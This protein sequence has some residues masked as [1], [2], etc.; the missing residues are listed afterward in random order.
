MAENNDI[1]VERINLY[2]CYFLGAETVSDT[3]GTS[4]QNV[5]LFIRDDSGKT[6]KAVTF[7]KDGFPQIVIQLGDTP[8]KL[9]Q[10]FGCSSQDIIKA[11]QKLWNGKFFKVGQTVIIPQ[12]I[13]I[14]NKYLATRKTKEEAEEEYK[15][16]FGLH[17]SK[18]NVAKTSKTTPT[19]KTASTAKITKTSNDTEAT[20]TTVL[21]SN[22][23]EIEHTKDKEIKPKQELVKASSAN[24]TTKKSISNKWKSIYANYTP[25]SQVKYNRILKTIKNNPNLKNKDDARYI[26]NMVCIISERYG[27]DPEI[28][29]NILSHESNFV[30]ENW[31]MDPPEKKYKGVMQVGPGIIRSMY[32][33]P[34]DAT[35]M[36]I[37]LQA[38]REAGDQKHYTN[39]QKRIDELKKMY[40]TPD[41]LLNA[42]KTDVALGIE[43][44]IIAY[45][46]ALSMNKG[47]TTA[48]IAQYCGSQYKLPADSLY[49]KVDPIPHKIYPIPKY[50]G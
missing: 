13:E 19:N 40:L 33:D 5:S 38:R 25:K 20:S 22:K 39:D 30:F 48:A 7:N 11:N 29:V 18:Q 50:K 12:K 26:A 15:S 47:N 8:K 37:S 9:A 28:T 49:A 10:M 32:A 27:L 36:K 46:G 2:G 44:G 24:K 1:N 42:I 41:D 4:T 16:L 43:V 31:T 17:L 6:N 45:K 14:D 3:N 34:K 21:A 23:S 35:N